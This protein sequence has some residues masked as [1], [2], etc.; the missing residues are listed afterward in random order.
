MTTPSNGTLTN[1]IPVTGRNTDERGILQPCLILQE[2]SM[3]NDRAIME[4]FGHLNFSAINILRYHVYFHE[5][6]LNGDTLH[7][8][9]SYRYSVTGLLIEIKVHKIRTRK[10]IMV[11]TGDFTFVDTQKN[12]VQSGLT[13]QRKNTFIYN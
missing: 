12:V 6:A 13:N 2:V 5:A 1:R 8:E 10:K 11:L 7:I 3:I 4:A 9:A